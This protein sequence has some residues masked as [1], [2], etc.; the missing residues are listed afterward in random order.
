LSSARTFSPRALI[1][2]HAIELEA[3]LGQQAVERLGLRHGARETVEHEAAFGVG[4]VDAVGDD[5]HHHFV[6][7]QFAAFHDALGAQADRRTGGDRGAQHVAR[8]ELNDPVLDDQPLRLR[9][10]PSPRGPEQNQSHRCR[11]RSFERLIR[12]SY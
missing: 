4:L 9:A 2:D 7:H 12:P 1:S 6:R 8:R 3:A 10:L 5:R 11:P